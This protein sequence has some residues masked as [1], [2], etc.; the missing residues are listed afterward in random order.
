MSIASAFKKSLYED[1]GFRQRRY[2]FLFLL[3][4]LLLFWLGANNFIK[5]IGLVGGVAVSLDMILLLFVYARAKD[6]G[7]RIPEYSLNIPNVVLYAMM[8]IFMLGAVYTLIGD[9]IPSSL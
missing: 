4:P 8:F 5:I 1:Y 2:F 6:H 9:K 3:P 7:N